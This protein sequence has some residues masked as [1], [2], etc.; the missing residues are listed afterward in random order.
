MEWQNEVLEVLEIKNMT[1][2]KNK[3][4][5]GD[6]VYISDEGFQFRLTTEDGVRISNEIFLDDQV[7]LSFIKYIERMRHVKIVVESL[8]HEEAEKISRPVEIRSNKVCQP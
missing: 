3:S 5:L 1:E 6:S 4:Y 7:L 2:A 8:P